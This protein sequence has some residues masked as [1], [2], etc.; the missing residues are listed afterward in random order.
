MPGSVGEG[1]ISTPCAAGTTKGVDAGDKYRRDASSAVSHSPRP[2][3]SHVDVP[4]FDLVLPHNT[5]GL[6]DGA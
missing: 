3:V 2:L 6:D 4:E 5:R 1:M